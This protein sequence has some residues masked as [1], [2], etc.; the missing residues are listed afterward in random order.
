MPEKEL[1][2]EIEEIRQRKKEKVDY[3]KKIHGDAVA[4][5]RTGEIGGGVEK[6]HELMR[7]YRESSAYQDAKRIVGEINIDRLLSREPMPGKPPCAG[8][9]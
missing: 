6:L 1:Q 9:I 7:F 5:L 2:A 3:G 8:L 4:L